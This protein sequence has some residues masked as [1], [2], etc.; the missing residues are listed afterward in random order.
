MTKS[1]VEKLISK[2]HEVR[3]ELGFSPQ[4]R[5]IKIPDPKRA[6]ALIQKGVIREINSANTAC[7][8]YEVED[9]FL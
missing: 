4:N 8:V 7:A 5:Q 6:E 3:K 9:A 2:W 1:D